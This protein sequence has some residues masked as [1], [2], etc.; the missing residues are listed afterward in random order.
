MRTLATKYPS[1][2]SIKQKKPGNRL[3]FRN[4]SGLATG[5][6]LLQSK[7]ACGG[8]CPR[9]QEELGI[10][11]KLK[12]GEPGDKYEQEADRVAT[13]ITQ[14]PEPTIQRQTETEEVECIIN[15]HGSHLPPMGTV[16][17]LPP[18]RSLL[19]CRLTEAQVQRSGNWCSD[20]HPH[21]GERCYRS[22]P[23]RS[24]FTDCPLGHQYCFTQNG[25]CHS[26]PDIHS[27]V[28]DSSPSFP[29]QCTDHPFC[30]VQHAGVDYLP[31]K[32]R[33]LWQQLPF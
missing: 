4:P 28:D 13:Q 2:D 32:I 6:P 11:T 8:G 16:H 14:M 29:G 25:C 21:R 23:T 27:P 9:C 12:I 3:R 10:Q 19:P 20:N 7:C 26:S 17:R 24:S 33:D 1:T 31:S 15:P 22:I 18:G 5:M 30:V